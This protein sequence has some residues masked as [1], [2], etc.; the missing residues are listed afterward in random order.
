MG[1]HKP[2]PPI[3]A[4]IIKSSL[5]SLICVGIYFIRE[6]L[7]IG[8]GIP[9]YSILAVLWCTQPYTTSTLDKAK[10]RTIGTFLGAAFGL[11]FLLVF[12]ALG[13]ANKAVVY[14][15]KY[16]DQLLM[17]CAI[18]NLLKGAVGQAVQNMNLMF[19]IDEKAGLRLKA[20][21]F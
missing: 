3:G 2:L 11:V 9:F 12:R 17:I 15:E 7:P 18:D 14:V 21:A 10:Q 6:L 8:S 16:E 5:G 13:G 19:G 1:K 20:S 4:R